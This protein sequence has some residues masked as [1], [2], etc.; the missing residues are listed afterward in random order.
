MAAARAGGLGEAR[1][2]RTLSSPLA[3]EGAGEEDLPLPDAWSEASSLARVAR[4]RSASATLA[5]RARV[6]SSARRFFS[7]ATARAA[8]LRSAAVAAAS[9]LASA[10]RAS[11]SAASAAAL[12]ATVAGAL[13][14]AGGAA[15]DLTVV[16]LEGGAGE[17]RFG[18][19]VV[20]VSSP[21][22]A[23]NQGA[24]GCSD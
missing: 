4:A 2:L 13:A 22:R 23:K 1:V 8:F 14:R 7:A 17:A 3:A 16:R 18:A 12:G 24:F 20:A 6:A 10:R 15:A 5:A 11:F 19:V 21:F 9:R